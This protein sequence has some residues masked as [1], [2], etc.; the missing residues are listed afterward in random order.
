MLARLRANNRALF[1]KRLANTGSYA[2]IH[3]HY[4]S[5]VLASNLS[6]IVYW[7]AL[8]LCVLGPWASHRNDS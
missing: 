6:W 7:P 8:S 1:Q 5:V 4:L 3:F 2:R